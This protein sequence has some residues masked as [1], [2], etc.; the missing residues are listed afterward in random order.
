MT[1]RGVRRFLWPLFSDRF[2]KMQQGLSRTS[3]LIPDADEI[4]LEVLQQDLA[5]CGS[6]QVLIFGG[7]TTAQSVHVSV[8]CYRTG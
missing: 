4:L 8:S 5:A 1:A 7:S 2:P 6:S 3:Y